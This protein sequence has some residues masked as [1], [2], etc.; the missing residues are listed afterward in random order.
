MHLDHVA[1]QVL[2]GAE[3]DEFLVEATTLFARVMLLREMSFLRPG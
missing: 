1:F 3:H 2:L